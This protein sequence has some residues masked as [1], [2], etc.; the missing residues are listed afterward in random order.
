VTTNIRKQKYKNKTKHL[1][2]L[3]TNKLQIRPN[4]TY[5]APNSTHKPPTTS[6]QVAFEHFCSQAQ[7]PRRKP[8]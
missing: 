6:N 1:R 2:Y 7:T 3:I 5:I 8:N 4:N